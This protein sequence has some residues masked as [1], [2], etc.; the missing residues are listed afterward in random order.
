MFVGQAVSN[1]A[2]LL[3]VDNWLGVIDCPNAAQVLLGKPLSEFIRAEAIKISFF[4]RRQVLQ[5]NIIV[6][7]LNLGLFE[8]HLQN[9]TVLVQQM[10]QPGLF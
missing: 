5:V 2:L 7:L 9:A 4:L 3:D 1:G 6:V 8:Q 10:F